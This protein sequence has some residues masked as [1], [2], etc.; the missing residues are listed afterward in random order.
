MHPP[1]Q[2]IIVGN[3]CSNL[4]HEACTL[5]IVKGEWEESFGEHGKI[6]IDGKKRYSFISSFSKTCSCLPNFKTYWE[7]LC[8]SY[9]GT[10]FF[11]PV[12]TVTM[13]EFKL[14]KFHIFYH[15]CYGPNICLTFGSSHFWGKIGGPK[16]EEISANL[17]AIELVP[18]A[19]FV[20]PHRRN[21][22]TMNLA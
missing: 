14:P 1:L 17:W 18:G 20:E 22:V 13:K 6:C 16:G 10:L 15:I 11:H 5:L 4:A 3:S 7:F 12:K 21:M 19:N 8:K 2:S 9:F